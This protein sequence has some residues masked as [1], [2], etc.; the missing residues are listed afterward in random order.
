MIIKKL[1]IGAVAGAGVLAVPAAAYADSCANVSRAPAPCGWT[2]SAPVTV[3]NWVW[4]PSVGGPFAWGFSVPGGFDS[5]TFGFPGAPGNYTNGFTSS[6]LGHS[7]ICLGGVPSRQ[8]TSGIQ[9][10]CV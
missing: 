1:L 6:L 10:G 5:V 3:G 8:T 4:L 2:C 7:A 9:T